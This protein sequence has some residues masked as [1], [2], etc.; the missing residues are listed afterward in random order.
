M[1]A[2]TRPAPTDPSVSSPSRPVLPIAVVVTAHGA[3]RHLREALAGVATQTARPARTVVVD[4]G[5]PA[6]DLPRV[7]GAAGVEIL[8]HPLGPNPGRNRAVQEARQPWIAFLDSEDTWSPHKLATQW[9]ALEACPALDV[10]FA[11]SWEVSEARGTRRPFLEQKPHYWEVERREV[12]PGVKECEPGSLVRQ[13]LRGNFLSRSTLL[14]R[15]D[16]LMRTTLFDRE[17]VHLE[18]RECWLRLLAIARFG[19]IEEPLME[20]RL[21]EDDR[22]DRR[23]W[24]YESALDLVRLRQMIERHPDEYPA[25]A[26]AHYA[27]QRGRASLAVGRLA[28]TA[29]RPDEARRHYVRAWWLGGGTWPLVRAAASYLPASGRDRLADLKT[30]C[31][32]RWRRS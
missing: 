6:A 5:N 10:L 9:R 14:V 12:A 29:G 30:R 8:R 2:T 27:A 23:N 3:A 4:D 31:G 18:D 22:P 25:E 16:A 13:F 7:A 1:N 21:D 32:A 17:L 19:V 28:E 20:S 26:V 11:N 24:A 15:R